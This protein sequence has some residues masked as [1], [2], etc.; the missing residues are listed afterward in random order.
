MRDARARFGA[1]DVIVKNVSPNTWRRGSR[2]HVA[3]AGGEERHTLIVA[4]IFGQPGTDDTI[5]NA[6]PAGHNLVLALDTALDPGA[7]PSSRE[8]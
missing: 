4:A 3:V 5:L 2:R 7:Q 1:V 6:L 8:T